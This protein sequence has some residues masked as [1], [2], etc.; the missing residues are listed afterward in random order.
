MDPARSVDIGDLRRDID[1]TRD[2]ISRTASALRGKAGDAMHWQTYVGRYPVSSLLGAVLLGA[3][4]GRR[5]ARELESGQDPG[6]WV[7]AAGLEAVTRIPARLEAGGAV[8]TAASASWERLGGRVEGLVNRIIDDVAD[9]LERA[10]L[11][12]LAGAVEAFL[13]G[14]AGA[15]ARRPAA[16]RMPAQDAGGRSMA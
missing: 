10:V 7:A 15:P 16:D 1:A 6:P 2:S 9:A 5:L 14:P 11:P 8:P 4:V 3:A 13:G 12:A